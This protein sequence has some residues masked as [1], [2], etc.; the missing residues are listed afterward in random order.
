MDMNYLMFE[1]GGYDYQ[2]YQEYTA[3]DNGTN[4]GIK[5]TDKSTK[6]ETDIKGNGNTIEGS[7]INLRDN[8]KIKIENL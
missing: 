4:V 8:K 3:K 1:N 2:I 7:L 5:V 6:K